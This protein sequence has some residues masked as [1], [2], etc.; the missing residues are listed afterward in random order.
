MTG[1]HPLLWRWDGHRM[2]GMLYACL[3]LRNGAASLAA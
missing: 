3:A 2:V 1:T